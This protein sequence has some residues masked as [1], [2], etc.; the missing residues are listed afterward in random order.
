[1]PSS[2]KKPFTISSSSNLQ[3]C[4]KQNFSTLGEIIGWMIDGRFRMI[5]PELS[6]RHYIASRLNMSESNLSLIISNQRPIDLSN[7]CLIVTLCD[8]PEAFEFLKGF[9]FPKIK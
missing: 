1:M 5:H 8:A 9:N 6:P 7:F 3:N 2:K 4:E